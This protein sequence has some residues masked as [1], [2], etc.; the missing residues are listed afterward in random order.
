MRSS[1]GP[2][3]LPAGAEVSAEVEHLAEYLLEGNFEAV[4]HDPLVQRVLADGQAPYADYATLDV[5]FEQLIG[6]Y[7]END[8]DDDIHKQSVVFFSAV[9]CLQLFVQSNWVGPPVDIIPADIFPAAVD[10]CGIQKFTEATL[11]ALQ[12]NGEP[13]YDLVAY[14]F[15]LL[16]ART[17]LVTCQARLEHFKM[18]PWWTLR[19]LNVHQNLLGDR[20]PVLYAAAQSCIE[21]VGKEE[22]LQTSEECRH[23]AIQFHLE[24]AYTFLFYYDYK[25]AKEGF[26]A[27]QKMAGLAI[28]LIGALGKRTQF[29]QTDVAQL[30]VEVKREDNPLPPSVLSP[31][32]TPS[33][34]MPKD[35][36]LGDDLLLNKVK[37]AHPEEVHM[38]E[39]CA[40]ELAVV[41]GVCTD[42]QKNSPVHRLTTEEISAFAVL[43]LSQ[44]KF[45]PIQVTA[46]M[47]RTK[48]EKMSTRRVERAMMQTQALLDHLEDSTP[49]VTERLKVF[50]C[51][52][53]PP[54]WAIKRELA[55]LL[56]SL[57]CNSAALQV[58]EKLE[59]WEDVIVCY[60]RTGQHGKAEEVVQQEL[61]KK[62]TPTL[63]CL[64]GD[65]TRQYEPYERAWE[66]SGHR[67][68]RAQRSKGLLHLRN[69][70]F[71]E[72]IACFERSVTI[73]PLQLG[74]W[75]SLGCAYMAT[76]G[77]DG[78]ARAFQRC[79]TLEPD[80]SEAWN[81][82]STAYIRLNQKLKAY[83]ALQEALRCNYESWQ[84]WE[85]YILTS[86]DVGDFADVIKAYHRMMDL[87]EG[88]NDEEVLHIVV[89]AVTEGLPDFKGDSA[90]ALLGKARE[91]MG[92]VTSRV[93]S[94]GNVWRLYAKLYSDGTSPSQEDND[95]VLQFLSKA[96]RCDT[97]S[98]DWEK[99]VNSFKVVA[100]RAVELAQVSIQCA[101]KKGSAQEAMQLLSSARLSLRGLSAKAKQQQHTDM[102]TGELQGDLMD[103]VRAMDSL[104][105]ELQELCNKLRNSV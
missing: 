34:H 64:L 86:A 79:V 82:L 21:Q 20:S 59:M 49:N 58:Y 87:K 24:A 8:Q 78:A 45:W 72:C 92:R 40:E 1:G 77:Y 6:S 67:S 27:A 16:L 36:Q 53:V 57:G 96:H 75:F 32:P 91:L 89:R 80:N 103:I 102:S 101:K 97:L 15:L 46:L 51:C 29:Q 30:I 47:L 43:I 56:F 81:N 26:S 37:L 35:V 44:P 90:A 41:L 10:K 98:S 50:F 22:E 74:V 14:P 65:V 70:E 52:Q 39:L 95:K 66:V 71:L 69:K 88:Y 33:Q 54:K 19:C 85:N 100:N 48:L 23:L 25:R 38:P 7:F 42:L 13:V 94:N 76:E 55:S 93:T 68:A 5:Y 84:I 18:A 17:I 3:R 2:W 31:S 9:A 12:V 61:A 60:E 105:L 63:L 99:D 62:E 73:N 4:L 104:G 28:N 11:S 83:R